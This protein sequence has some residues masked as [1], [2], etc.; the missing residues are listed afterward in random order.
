MN[1]KICVYVIGIFVISTIFLSII[2]V[3]ATK[4]KEVNSN[5]AIYNHGFIIVE[6][7]STAGSISG[8]PECDHVGSLHDVEIATNGGC[9]SLFFTNPVWGSAINYRYHD[10]HIQMEHFL[11]VTTSYTNGGCLVGICKNITW[12]IIQ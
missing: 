11:G 4:E 8:I 10:V 5:E 12:E 6:T 9:I 1:R 2:P 3:T 7:F